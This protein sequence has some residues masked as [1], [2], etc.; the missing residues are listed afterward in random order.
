MKAGWKAVR[1]RLG[2]V[3]LSLA[4]A[5]ITAAGFAAFSVAAD[6]D[7]DGSRDE[8]AFGVAGPGPGPGGP[9]IMLRAEGLSEEDEQKLENFR[10]C[11]ED[12]GLPAPPRFREGEDPPEPPSREEFEQL[13]EQ[14]E[15]AHE[16]CKDELPEELRERGFPPLGHAPC[17]PPPGPRDRED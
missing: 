1:E 11:M 16:T 8:R 10:Q 7:K 6:D 2:P 9:G 4:A 14:L 12:Q 13:R 15:A 5:A 3:G 17:G